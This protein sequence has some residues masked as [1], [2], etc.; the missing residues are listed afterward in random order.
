MSQWGMNMGLRTYLPTM[1]VLARAVCKY[2]G[3]HEAKIK[4]NLG[5]GNANK[6]DAALTACAILVAALEATIEIGA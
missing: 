6:V 4:S 2:I 5:E 3:N 1:L